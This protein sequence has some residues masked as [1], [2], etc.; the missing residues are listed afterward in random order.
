MIWT[1]GEKIPDLMGETTWAF[2]A[3]GKEV[4][5]SPETEAWEY[6][7]SDTSFTVTL[8]NTRV[9]REAFAYLLGMKNAN[10]YSRAICRMKRK[11]EQER[12]RRLKEG[13]NNA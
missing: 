11:K 8:R 13:S 4:K 10:C 6:Q 3:D 2:S 12:R 9:N 7:F 5:V 1:D